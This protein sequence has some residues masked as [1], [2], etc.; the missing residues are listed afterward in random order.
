MPTPWPQT[1]AWLALLALVLSSC[2]NSNAIPSDCREAWYK[3]RLDHFRWARQFDQPMFQQRYFL[4]DAH[5]KSGGPVFFYAGNEGPLEG[6]LKSAGLMFENREQ[7]GA[8][9]VFAEVSVPTTPAML[10]LP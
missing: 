3:Q 9:V 4:C 8:L 10:A 7:Y 2:V 6:Y 5:W 1:C